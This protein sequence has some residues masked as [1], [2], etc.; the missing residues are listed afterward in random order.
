DDAEMANADARA[1]WDSLPPFMY[2]HVSGRTLPVNWG[3]L[4]IRRR[5]VLFFHSDRPLALR[6]RLDFP[7]GLPGV[8]WPGT[9]LPATRGNIRPA[10][11]GTSLEWQLHLKQPPEGQRPQNNNL[12]DVSRGHWV[13]QMRAVKCDDVYSVFGDGPIDVDHEKFVF[14]DGLFPQGKWL[15]VTVAKDR[16]ALLSRV[17]HPVFDVTVIDR[18]GDGKVRVGRLDKLD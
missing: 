10:A 12:R 11:V 2:G 1:E 6:M 16:V 13:E 4:E 17:S 9:R 15:R 7:G 5:P 18:R 8:W 14:Y 3:A